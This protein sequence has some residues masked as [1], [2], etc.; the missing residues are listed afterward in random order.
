M[1]SD[2]IKNLLGF[3]NCLNQTRL[4]LTEGGCQ[5]FLMTKTSGLQ[6]RCADNPKIVNDIF[7]SVGRLKGSGMI[8]RHM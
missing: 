3:E 6:K 4:V 2:P 1:T 8:D 7:G 5:A